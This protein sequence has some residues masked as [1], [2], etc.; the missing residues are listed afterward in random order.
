M[1]GR[2]DHLGLGVNDLL[3][4]H[5]TVINPFRII[6]HGPSATTGTTAEIV[7]TIGVHLHII[8]AALLRDPA[9]LFE[10]RL[11]E[12]FHAL[13]TVITGIVNRCEFFMNG[14]VKFDPSGFNVFL[15]EFMHGNNSDL[16]EY[17]GIPRLQT[18]PSRE[19]SV[20]SLGQE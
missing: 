5:P 7:H 1:A 16:V 8:F 11:A 3:S 12:C 10:K 20:A 14:F 13:S 9:G 6:G 19:I 4:F 17:F 2:N 15:Q 18:K